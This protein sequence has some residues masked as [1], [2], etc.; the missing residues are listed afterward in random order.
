LDGKRASLQTLIEEKLS[1]YITRES[2]L[3]IRNIT[4]DKKR[5][6]IEKSQ[7]IRKT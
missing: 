6:Y 4:R 2:E 1:G 5:Y 3:K 7:L